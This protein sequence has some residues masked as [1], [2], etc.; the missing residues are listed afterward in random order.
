MKNRGW[1]GW[2]SGLG[3]WGK[4]R[5]NSAIG[6]LYSRLEKSKVRDVKFNDI[7]RGTEKVSSPVTIMFGSETERVFSLGVGSHLH[8]DQVRERK[9]RGGLDREA[10]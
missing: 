1:G 6:K 8:G 4:L 9:N 2:K 5:R 7:R 3:E 10:K